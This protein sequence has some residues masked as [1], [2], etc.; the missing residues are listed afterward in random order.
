MRIRF[1]H[2]FDG[3]VVETDVITCSQQHWANRPESHDKS[4]SVAK[5]PRSRVQAVQ[6][7]L[8]VKTFKPTAASK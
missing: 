6:L 8:P 7:C 1:R 4:W 2:I 5:L 3:E